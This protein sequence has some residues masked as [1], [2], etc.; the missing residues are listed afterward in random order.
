MI[1]RR[2]FAALA[3][4]AVLAGATAT[5]ASADAPEGMTAAEYRALQVRSEA[6]NSRY[7][8]EAF[9]ALAV[10]S[11]GLNSYAKTLQA[12]APVASSPAPTSFAWD[13]FG[14]G[15]VAAFS[16]VL[17]MGGFAVAIRTATRRRVRIPS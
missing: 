2:T 4:G 3:L 9:N 13:D 7:G 10:R 5:A 17:L 11:E 15:V 16:L 8:T 6:L 1:V 12:P 14:A